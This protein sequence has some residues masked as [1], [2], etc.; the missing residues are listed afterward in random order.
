ARSSFLEN[1]IY[2]DGL[3]HLNKGVGRYTAAMTVCC[4]LTG[5]DPDKITYAPESLLKNLPE[6]LNKEAPGMQET[7]VK[8]AKESVKNALAKPYEITQSQYKTAP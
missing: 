2:R 7:L 6:G 5:V 3:S 4:T 8:I 1:G